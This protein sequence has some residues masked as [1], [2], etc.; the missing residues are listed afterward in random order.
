MTP[1]SW[2]AAP[3]AWPSFGAEAMQTSQAD[4]ARRRGAAM[5]R[6]G[7]GDEVTVDE[8]ASLRRYGLRPDRTELD[9]LRELLAE[10]TEPLHYRQGD[11]G[12]AVLALCCA[13]YCN[14]RV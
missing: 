10:P 8:E 13:Q 3:R 4:E 14:A 1:S 7:R 12:T 9:A 2:S 11:V 6:S 5:R